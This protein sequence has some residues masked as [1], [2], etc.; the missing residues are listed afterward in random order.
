LASTM[1]ESDNTRLIDSGV[2]GIG[3]ALAPRRAA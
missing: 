3:A 2:Q 1:T